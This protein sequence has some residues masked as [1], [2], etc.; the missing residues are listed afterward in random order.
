M[1]YNDLHSEIGLDPGPWTVEAVVDGGLGGTA[2]EDIV[3][4][5][6]VIDVVWIYD[7]DIE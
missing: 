4:E 2:I 5:D 1:D 6:G 7:S 3:I